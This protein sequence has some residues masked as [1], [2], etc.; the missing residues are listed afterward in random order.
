MIEGL[1]RLTETLASHGEI[2]RLILFGSRAR[3]DA[4]ARA[5][6]DLAVEAPG[7]TRPQWLEIVRL[8]E[9][10]PTLLTI[11]LV[12]MDEVAPPL[13]QKILLE[14]IILYDRSQSHTEPAESLKSD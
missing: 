14:G 10:A 4:D 5:D 9:E 8:V 12:R 2:Q 1:S 3:G 6:I 13:R 7:T 11:D